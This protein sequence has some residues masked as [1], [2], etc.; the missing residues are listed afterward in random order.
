VSFLNKGEFAK[1]ASDPATLLNAIPRNVVDNLRWRQEFHAFLAENAT[2]QKIFLYNI[3][4]NP[5]I[6]YNSCGWTYNPKKD[7]RARNVPF[8][9]RPAQEVAIATLKRAIDE[10]F[11]VAI[12]KSREEGASELL[13]KLFL[14]YWLLDQDTYM[15][16]GSRKEELVDQSTDIKCG[17]VIGPHQTLFHKILYGLANLPVWWKV[18]YSKRHRFLQNLD[19][20]SMIEGEATNES[21]GAGNRATAVLIDEV[22]R[23]EPE[24]AQ[25]IIDNIHD[26]TQCCIY[27]STH[28]KWGAGHPYAKLLRSNKIE[29]ITLAWEDNPEKNYG[30]YRSPKQGLIEIKDIDYYRQKC[31]ALFTE[32]N[33]GE[34]VEL[35]TL[36]TEAEKL[37]VKE[38][39]RFVADGGESNF[40]RWRSVWFDDEV[41]DRARS[42]MDIAQNILRVPQGAADMFFDNAMVERIRTRFQEKHTQRYEIG[43]TYGPDG[44]LKDFA[45]QEKSKGKLKW[46]GQLINGRPNKEHNYIVSCDISY[47]KGASNSVA[48][49]CDVNTAEVV[50]IAV[51]PYMS[52]T[53][54][55]DFAIA[56]AKWAQNAY[57]IWEANG[58][59]NEFDHRVRFHKYSRVYIS[60]PERQR[61]QHQQNQRGWQSTPGINGSKLDMLN[62][63]DSALMESLREK[64]SGTYL[65]VHDEE[66]LRELDDYIFDVHKIDVNP[67]N[68]ITDSSGARYAH[69]DRVIAVGMSVIAMELSPKA[70]TR[71]E[72]LPP[73]ESVEHRMQEAKEEKAKEKLVGYHRQFLYK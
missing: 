12:D 31:P 13:C 7:S 18:N 9:L 40:G 32:M 60:R 41:L 10:G 63:L 46:W 47:G 72:A 4:L 34:S 50:G 17:H 48:A 53:D 71:R 39:F 26:T 62:R 8:I 64:H 54:F 49:V 11:D 52:I 36:E 43:W 45:C 58:P 61:V 5:V 73:A 70:V 21:F 20:G 25:Y 19:N 29:V 33:A 55:A 51:D 3:S 68:S 22:A 66:T 59:G 42:M 57:L 6:W 69:G 28:F 65:I 14:C 56:L 38:T 30:M 35:I 1:I 15:L 16:V 37:H 2:A 24:P 23:I 44:R 67:S 27:N